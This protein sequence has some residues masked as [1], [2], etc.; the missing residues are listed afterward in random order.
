[1]AAGIIHRHLL[2]ALLTTNEKNILYLIVT[3]AKFYRRKMR[4]KAGIHGQ[5]AVK[6]LVGW[7][8]DE[9]RPLISGLFYVDGVPWGM[10]H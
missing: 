1:M 9:K 3:T 4:W 6:R 10:V 2:K 8:V 7:Y 5:S